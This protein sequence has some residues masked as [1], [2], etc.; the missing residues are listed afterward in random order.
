MGSGTTLTVANRMRRNSIGI[1]IVPQYF[2]TVKDELKPLELY[3]LEPK[4]K[5]ETFEPKRRSAI[6]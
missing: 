1:E 6:R 5:Y 3:L 2:Q 4:V